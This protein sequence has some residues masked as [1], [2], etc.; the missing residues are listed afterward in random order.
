[1]KKETIVIAAG[2]FWGVQEYFR[3][4][5]GTVSTEVGYAQGIDEH[6][7][8][9]KV[10][11][12]QSGHVEACKL[13]YDADEISLNDILNHMF[14]I[15]D[16]L[17]YHKQGGDVGSQY[18]TGVYY[19][20]EEEKDIIV[21]FIEEQQK[22]YDSLIRVECEKLRCFFPAETY[23]QEYLVKNPGGYCHVDFH[24]IKEQE[25]KDEYK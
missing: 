3:R 15:I 4:I 19:E 8:Y 12:Q 20:K 25:L 17:S 11:T 13:I 18:R 7:T 9:E 23:H 24:K 6:P 16:P 2:C 22:H 10:C 14:R 5:K 21:S 1:M